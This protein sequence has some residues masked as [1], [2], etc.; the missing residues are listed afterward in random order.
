MKPETVIAWHRQG[1]RLYWKWKSKVRHGRPSVPTEVQNLIQKMSSANPR[2]GA[3]RLHGELRKLGIRLAQATVAKS[4]VRHRKPPSQTWRTFLE[5][6]AKELVS[7]DFFVVPTATFRLLFVFLVLSHDRRL[8]HFGVTSHPT[9]EWTA[10]QLVQ[11]FPW[12]SAPRYLLR[13]RDRIYGE[14]FPAAVHSMG[15]QEVL[16]APHSPWQNPYCERLIGSIRRECLDHFIVCN[17]RCL[18]RTLKSYFEYYER[19]R[20]HLSLDKDAP[21]TRA[22][23]PPEMGRVIELPQVGGLHHRYER[24]AA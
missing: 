14:P 7:T 4:M 12:D 8:L 17:E 6:H 20:T 18:H 3:P 2:W 16:T 13:D 21:L 24:R 11:A 5:N 1:F 10:R 22:I 15:I 19:S 9:A 23:H